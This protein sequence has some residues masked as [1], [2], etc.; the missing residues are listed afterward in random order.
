ML[1]SQG[2]LARGGSSSGVG[3]AAQQKTTDTFGK[4]TIQQPPFYLTQ[5]LSRIVL[6]L[7]KL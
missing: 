5:V 6:Y 3:S 7:R 4:E 2:Y 1:D